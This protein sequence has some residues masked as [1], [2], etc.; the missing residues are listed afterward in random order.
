MDLNSRQIIIKRIMNF[1]LCWAFA[2]SHLDVK[3][4]MNKNVVLFKAI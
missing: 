2:T 3:L 1:Y 4:R